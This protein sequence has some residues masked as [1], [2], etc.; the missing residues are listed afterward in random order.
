M[1]K[2]IMNETAMK[3]IWAFYD[4]QITSIICKNQGKNFIHYP[5][6]LTQTQSYS[7]FV[8]RKFTRSTTLLPAAHVETD[9]R[10]GKCSAGAGKGH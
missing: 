4:M 3:T 10:S 2:Q 9:N 1:S 8:N 5:I 7:Q 6:W